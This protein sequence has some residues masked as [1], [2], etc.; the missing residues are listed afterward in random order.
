MAEETT[1]E[2]GLPP[3]QMLCAYSK[4][5]AYENHLEDTIGTIE[6]VT[7]ADLVVLGQTILKIDPKQIFDTEVVYTIS[8]GTIVYDG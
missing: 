7:K 1:T 5:V 6:V 3:Y 4:N 8:N 2:Q